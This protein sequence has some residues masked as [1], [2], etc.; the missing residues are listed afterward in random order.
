ME[1]FLMFVKAF[2]VGGLICTVGQIIINNTKLT[3]GKILVI[4][5]LAGVILEAFG[6]YQYLVDFAGAG[7]TIPISG[8]GYSL[9][10][11]VIGAVREKGFLGIFT[12]G[13]INTAAGITIA[14]F[15]SYLIG[16]IFKPKTKTM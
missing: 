1:I 5:L 11:G 12:G 16:L 13:I 14:V 10:K 7:A 6:L 3:N 4:F 9:S 2:V 15:F 8:F